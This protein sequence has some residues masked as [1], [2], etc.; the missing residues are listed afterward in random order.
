MTPAIFWD[1]DRILVHTERLSF[2]A[3][4]ET[5]ER[6]GVPLTQPEYVRRFMVQ[7]AGRPEVGARASAT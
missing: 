1:N 5:L 6:I 7:S 3:T 4:R 2:E